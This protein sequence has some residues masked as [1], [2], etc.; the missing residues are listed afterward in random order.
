[1]ARN[2]IVYE[3][4][5]PWR[6]IVL[7]LI[8][9]LVLFHAAGGWYFSDQLRADALVPA[10]DD[11]GFDV[12]VTEVGEGTIGLRASDG[13]DS[14]LTAPGIVGIDWGTGYGHLRDL[15]SEAGDGSV[16]R[17]MTRVD[18]D[19]PE[20]G[21]SANLDGAAFPDDPGRAFGLHYD[22]VQFSTP[23]G[24]M[25]AWEIPSTSS[26][27]VIHVHGLGTSRTEALRAILPIADSG[28]PQLVIT[29]RN[30]PGQPAD[31]SGYYGYGQ[32]EWEDVAAA[33][34]YTVSRGAEKVIL[35]GYSTGAA[36]I[37]SYLYRTPESPVVA[38]IFDSP[39][40][41]FEETV[42]LEASQ[43]DLPLIGIRLP[44][45]LVWTAKKISSARFGIDWQLTDYVS[46]ADQLRV[47]VLIF[48][49]TDDETVPLATSQEFF[50]A[51][52]DLIH[53]AIVPG[54]GHVRSWNVSPEP[55]ERRLIEFIG[56]FA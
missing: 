35:L 26:L 45:T 13:E 10:V 16:T 30:D 38:A 1:M 2:R 25:D 46:Q 53:L 28:D 54:A 48:H 15:I 39:N 37:L 43:R 55:Y 3:R 31:P 40:I 7:L 8:G 23:L 24:A 22:E 41:D 9:A 56:Q 33:V 42:N 27:W 14:N 12:L 49:G 21:M 34:D 11:A 29:Y 4:R 17:S 52:S 19:P 18:G 44:R 20:A 50:A 51:R 5:F 47:P 6:L 36:H 32:T